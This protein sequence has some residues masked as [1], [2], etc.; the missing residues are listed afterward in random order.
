MCINNYYTYRVIAIFLLKYKQII[1]A[2]FIFLYQIY[3]NF[4]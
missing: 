3:F 2:L 1:V 4:I